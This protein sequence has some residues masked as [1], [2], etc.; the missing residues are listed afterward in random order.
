MLPVNPAGLH[1]APLPQMSVTIF[2]MHEV[3]YHN[4]CCCNNCNNYN[5]CAVCRR[6][7]QVNPAGPSAKPAAPQQQP[8]A[9]AGA[10]GAAAAGGTG[11]SMSAYGDVVQED[12]V[13]ER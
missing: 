6:L 9:G 13:D 3:A 8:L 11:A 12:A 1:A 2:C 5:N 10:G 4:T 7:L